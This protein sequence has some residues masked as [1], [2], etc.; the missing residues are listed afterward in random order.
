VDVDFLV[1]GDDSLAQVYADAA[2][3]SIETST[4]EG[5]AVIGILVA[6]IVNGAADTL[7]VLADGQRALQPL[8]GI[9]AV[10]VNNQMSTY[11]YNKEYAEISNP[12]LLGYLREPTPMNKLPDYSQLKQSGYN[13]N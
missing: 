1:L 7:A 5:L 3:E 11:T 10:T 13:K 12:R 6:T 9:A 2:T 8:V 4:V